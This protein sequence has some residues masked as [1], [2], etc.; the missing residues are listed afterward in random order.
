MLNKRFFILLSIMVLVFSA[1]SAQHY[2]IRQMSEPTLIIGKRTLQ[3]GDSFSHEEIHS[4]K[5][6]SN[7]HWIEVKEEDTKDYL[8]LTKENVKGKRKLSPW[9]NL[10]NY[11]TK[12]GEL[13][14]RG[15]KSQV[16]KLD[17]LRLQILDTLRIPIPRMAEDS[18]YRAK[19]V[20]TDDNGNSYI[21]HMSFHQL[22]DEKGMYLTRQQLFGPH[23]PQKGKLT[24][25]RYPL[26]SDSKKD[27][28]GV[29]FIEPLLLP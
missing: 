10:W 22:Y 28:I 24:I 7:K 12:Q 27:S 16:K 26:Y 3:K 15:Q 5:W 8:T 1:V 18:I 13:T 4:I 29:L 11:I 14:V 21:T 17:T 9:E 2:T 20:S 23:T 19:F 25:Y 6:I